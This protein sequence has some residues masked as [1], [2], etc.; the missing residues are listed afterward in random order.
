VVKVTKI[1]SLPLPIFLGRWTTQ[2]YEGE[3]VIYAPVLRNVLFLLFVFLFV[4]RFVNK[5]YIPLP[6][7]NVRYQELQK[8]FET[9]DTFVFNP[10]PLEME[11]FIEMT[12]GYVF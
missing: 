6:D 10:N 2:F 5:I 7:R 11:C 9:N 8:L 1:S 12:E 4:A 3:G